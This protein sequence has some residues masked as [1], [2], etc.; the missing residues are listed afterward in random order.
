M[1]HSAKLFLSILALSV[2]VLGCKKSDSPKSPKPT[3]SA[4][5][6]QGPTTLKVSY[7]FGRIHSVEKTLPLVGTVVADKSVTIPSRAT[8][9][10]NEVYVA[11]GQRV[12]RGQTLATVD[13]SDSVL[14]VKR[15]QA[16]LAQELAVLGLN[17]PSEKLRSIDE[18]PSVIK[19]KAT[20]D[21]ALENLKRY[22]SLH[23][24]HLVSD[25]EYLQKKTAFVTAE[26]D[27]K[28]AKE[29]V[30][31]NLAS[32]RA[33][34][35]A[36]AIN[37]KKLTDAVIT[38]PVSGVLDQ[39][40][41]APGAY[42]SAGGD[43][44]MIILKDRPLYVALDVPQIHLAQVG[45]GRILRF[46]TPAYPDQLIS[47]RITQ[48]GGKV[49]TASG[50]IPARAQILNPP[51]WM[52]PGVAAEVELYTERLP[53]KLLI[54]QA[55]VLTQAGKS[56][57]FVVASASGKIAKVRKVSVKTGQ[58]T[59]DWIVVDGELME[60]DKV[61]TS[62]LLALDDQTEVELGQE[63]EVKVPES[64]R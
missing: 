2:V 51:S 44:G 4:T 50:D 30:S 7:S 38:A 20:M 41:T 29:G 19:A 15:S 49:N 26:A 16:Q 60:T 9:Q 61:I 11:E 13:T 52:V 18:I 36:V 53:D 56:S 39:V 10:I 42:V 14:A 3:T 48:M 33:A 64:L 58:Q 5:Q 62:D 25:E 55:G 35:Y 17:S 22:E 43:T 54:P 8:G 47:A 40:T 31:Q 27:Y 45:I 32:V 63:L 24:Q 12:S 1:G 57:V 34:Q 59:G 23:R 21:N 46:K 28:A 6:S 37:Q